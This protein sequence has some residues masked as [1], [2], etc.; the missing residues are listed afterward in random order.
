MLKVE[1]KS[2][3]STYSRLREKSFANNELELLPN[4]GRGARVFFFFDVD[5]EICWT[6]HTL[7]PHQQTTTFMFIGLHTTE[8]LL[9]TVR[10]E[11]QR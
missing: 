10:F 7:P 8:R 11:L 2:F 3:L 4:F 1:F 6:E 5:I 9:V